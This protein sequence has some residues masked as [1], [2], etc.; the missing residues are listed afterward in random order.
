MIL[1][2]NQVI[3]GTTGLVHLIASVSAL[4]LGTVSL[5]MTKGTTLHKKIGYGYAGAMFILLITAFML[6]TLF[7]R[8][9]IFHWA[10]VISALT[11]TAG[12]LPILVRPKNYLSFHLGFMYWSVVGLYG[13]FAA[14]VLVRIP[15]IVLE[16]GLP[17]KAFFIMTGMGVGLI[18]T[19]AGF[20]FSKLNPIWEK[21][22]S[23]HK[24]T[25]I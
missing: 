16:H 2:L 19:V 7:G 5:V 24:P 25:K 12:M 3:S 20:F 11:L 4:I 14:E 21:Q 18:M 6:Y 15:R 13:A 22:F 17:N 9:G 8:W 10:A 23:I 1:L